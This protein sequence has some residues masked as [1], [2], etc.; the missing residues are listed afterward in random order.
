MHQRPRILNFLHD[1]HEKKEPRVILGM[2]L[3]DPLPDWIT[4]V[5]QA[6]GSRVVTDVK[7]AQEKIHQAPAG[8]PRTSDD[9]VPRR[10][11]KMGEVIV[12]MVGVN[13][14]YHGRQVESFISNLLFVPHS[15]CLDTQARR[16]D[17]T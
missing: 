1:F 10:E 8:L 15:S 12:E 7:P 13:V 17:D 4:H 14:G 6:D 2:R 16:L 11:E 9:A 3:H 5:A